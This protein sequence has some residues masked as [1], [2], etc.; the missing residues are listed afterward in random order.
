MSRPTRTIEVVAGPDEFDFLLGS[1]DVHNRRRDDERGWEEFPGRST[2]QERLVDGLVQL[3]R[4]EAEW[5]TGQHVEALTAR[6]FDPGSEH[7]SIVWF[8]N[9][10]PHDFRPVVGAFADGVGHF[11]QVIEDRDGAP[12]HVEFV[13]DQITADS[14][15]WRQSFSLDGGTTWDLNWVMQLTRRP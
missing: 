2:V 9:R 15:R 8:S 6:A 10:Q 3:D 14:A 12:L 5:P 4:F 7:W 13:W 11:H 1:W